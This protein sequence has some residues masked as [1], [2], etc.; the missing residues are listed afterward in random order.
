[1]H[2]HHVLSPITSFR[3]K[4]TPWIFV[5]V[6]R[7]LVPI[8][9]V[10]RSSFPST[11]QKTSVESPSPSHAS[12]RSGKVAV[13]GLAVRMCDWNGQCDDAMMTANQLGA[14]GAPGALK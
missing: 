13:L 8:P 10:C 7:M 6:I 5:C 11:T 12:A 9:P 3:G 1:M 14:A 4:A 2:L